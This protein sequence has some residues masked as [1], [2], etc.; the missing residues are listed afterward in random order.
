M[1]TNEA[2]LSPPASPIIYRSESRQEHSAS[3]R[4]R[5]ADWESDIDISDDEG[6]REPPRRSRGKK[7]PRR[8]EENFDPRVD[9]LLQQVAA[10]TDL[11]LPKGPEVVETLEA[12]NNEEFVRPPPGL[13]KSDQTVE[14]GPLVTTVKEHPTPKADMKRVEEISKLQRFNKPEWAGVRYAETQKEYTA[15]PAFMELEVNE[16]LKRMDKAGPYSS[17]MDRTLGALSNALL[18]QRETLRE[19]MQALVNWSSN[20]DTVLTPTSLYNKVQETFSNDSPYKKTTD[21]ILQIVCGR[22]TEVIQSRRNHLLEDVKDNFIRE[23]ISKIPPSSCNLFDKDQLT[24]F[25]ERNGG[26][27]KALGTSVSQVTP[28]PSPSSSKVQQKR[29]KPPFQPRSS[30]EYQPP[31]AQSA[32]NKKKPFRADFVPRKDG[33]KNYKSSNQR[34]RPTGA[35]SRGG[36][37]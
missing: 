37:K 11:L 26:R 32:Q 20:T 12:P 9:F 15:S 17:L 33:Y 7:A 21:N 23:G 19:S 25:L 1:F 10:L 3:S 30:F 13:P 2:D 4:K 31:H 22:R 28:Q 36:R 34:Q 18:A 29:Y 8:S 24:A 14:F 27:E 16:E 35:N 5:Q 6:A